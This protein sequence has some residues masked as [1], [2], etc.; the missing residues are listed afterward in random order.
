[1]QATL[2][3][4]PPHVC[5][6]YYSVSKGD[7]IMMMLTLQGVGTHSTGTMTSIIQSV[8]FFRLFC[9]LVRSS[10]PP[11]TVDGSAQC[12]RQHNQ[13]LHTLT[14]SQHSHT[15]TLTH[16]HTHT[17]HTTSSRF[18][19]QRALSLVVRIF[20]IL[21]YVSVSHHPHI[22]CRNSGAIN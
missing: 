14:H 20:L 11:I 15:H 7:I 21:S 22:S 18:P 10:P 6:K 1:M 8:Y 19:V 13:L 17:T 2:S 3:M 4:H 5:R 16:S 9:L 12:S